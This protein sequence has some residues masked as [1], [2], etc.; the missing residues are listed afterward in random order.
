MENLEKF[1][2]PI[3]R[4]T[5]EITFPSFGTAKILENKGKYACDIVTELDRAVEV[6][7]K[8]ELNKIYPDIEFVGEEFGGNRNAKRFWLVDPIDGTGLYLRGLVGC[9]TM[10]AL[11]EDGQV[12]FSAIYDFVNDVMY[13]AE[14]DKGTYRDNERIHVSDRQSG[15]SYM[16][17]ET[18]WDKPENME[19]LL[20][21]HKYSSFMKFLASGYEFILIAEGK[22][23]GKVVF[24]PYGKDYDF[25]PGTLIVSE[26]GGVVTN[27][28][29]STYDYKNYS[30]LAVNVPMYKKL[31]EGPDALFPIK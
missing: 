30:F 27:L 19:I 28:G 23:E 16:A 12:I 22:L 18:H 9:T 21:L 26:A 6:Y 5:R 2:L 25:A 8:E 14:K 20:S 3:V 4:K 1:V 11:V 31:T 15:D 13:H 17:W 10:I 29:L 7:L 24:D